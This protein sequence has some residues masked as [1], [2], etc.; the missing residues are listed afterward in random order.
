LA[1]VH[2]G[3]PADQERDPDPALL[4][5]ALLA[6]ERP[7]EREALA[8]VIRAEADDR[9]PRDA[10]LVKRVE[11]PADAASSAATIRL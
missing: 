4:Q 7:Q 6:D 5:V 10:P 1:A 11:D 2:R 8:T 9:V 3:G